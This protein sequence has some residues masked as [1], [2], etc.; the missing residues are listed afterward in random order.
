MV[1]EEVIG[2]KT[3]SAED[4]KWRSNRTSRRWL[5]GTVKEHMCALLDTDE[6]ASMLRTGEDSL[7]SGKTK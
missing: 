1:C 7:I 6:F 5:Y 4:V 3:L 2:I